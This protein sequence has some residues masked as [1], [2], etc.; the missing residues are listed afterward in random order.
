MRS[1]YTPG[2]YRCGAS[3]RLT[4]KGMFLNDRELRS[5]P[6]AE[7]LRKCTVTLNGT[8]RPLADL[9]FGGTLKGSHR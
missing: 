9:R 3:K 4:D 2:D 8:V 6:G 7:W 5:P 1:A